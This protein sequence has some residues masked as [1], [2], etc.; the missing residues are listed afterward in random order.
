MILF[1]YLFEQFEMYCGV[2][3]LTFHILS[4]LGVFQ[5]A[6][7]VDGKNKNKIKTH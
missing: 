5:G 6:K 2:G 4:V 7:S 1:I 3:V